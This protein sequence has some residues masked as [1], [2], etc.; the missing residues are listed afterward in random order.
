M[1][2]PADDDLDEAVLEARLVGRDAL[3]VWPTEGVT[4]LGDAGKR[5]VC[6]CVCVCVYESL[7]VLQQL[8]D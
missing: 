3:P 6:V 7:C 8:T 1:T 4:L 2:P 5:C